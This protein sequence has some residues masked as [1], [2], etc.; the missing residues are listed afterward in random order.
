MNALV[1]TGST[2]VMLSGRYIE[3]PPNTV[4]YLVE[5]VSDAE[6][7]RMKEHSAI[8]GL[9]VEF[10]VDEVTQLVAV[11]DHTPDV[12][13]GEEETIV[14]Y[15]LKYRGVAAKG[16]FKLGLGVYDDEI[17]ET[18][19]TYANLQEVIK[20]EILD[21]EGT[22]EILTITAEDGEFSCKITNTADETV[23]LSCYP[24]PRGTAAVDT[25]DVKPLT[26]S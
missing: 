10:P 7:D 20:G 3:V 13:G 11:I 4:G 21:G 8:I 25:S 23:Y 2:G 24:P 18:P 16:K 12:T 9:R 15:K 17:G 5:G 19:A 1:T 6:I 14:G 22:G 26:F